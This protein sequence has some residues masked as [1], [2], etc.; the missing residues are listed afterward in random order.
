MANDKAWIPPT[1]VENDASRWFDEKNDASSTVNKDAVEATFLRLAEQQLL[2]EYA[3]GVRRYT[4]NKTA[5]PALQERLETYITRAAF[6]LSGA[7]GYYDQIANFCRGID[8]FKRSMLPANSEHYG[9]TFISR[10]RLNLTDMQIAQD[11]CFAPL[12]TEDPRSIPFM[13]RCYL[14]SQWANDHQKVATQCPLFNYYSP[15]FTPIVNGMSA[16]TGWPD[17]TNYTETSEG[18]WFQEDQTV[19]IGGDK[20]SK[21]Y[22][23]N[24]TFKDIQGG[25]IMACMDYWCKWMANACDGTMLPYA[26]AIDAN[27]LD[28]TVSIYRFV[29]DPT[30]RYV[31]KWAKATGCFPKS[32][33]FGAVFNVNQGEVFSEASSTLSVPF[34]ANHIGKY[35][36]PIILTEFNQLSDRYA[37]DMWLNTDKNLL[38]EDERPYA[39]QAINNFCGLPYIVTTRDGVELVFRRLKEESEMF[40][41]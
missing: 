25:I 16:I 9:F 17:P 38:V 36:D 14:D 4:V 31:T 39:L 27:R 33:P 28:Y 21:T 35:N 30:R 19:V 40:L 1:P 10:P 22:D 32:V 6:M 24:L 2:T 12:A 13:I 11:R 7:G 23:L 41:T 3:Q 20:L 37:K 5:M 29:V 18:G 15:W 8:R 34:V 26:D